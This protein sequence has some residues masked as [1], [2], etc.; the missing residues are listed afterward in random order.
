MQAKLKELGIY[1]PDNTTIVEMT[2]PSASKTSNL[3]PISEIIKLTGDPKKGAVVSA[4]CYTCHQIEGNGIA[5]GP[6]LRNWVANQGVEPFLR[7]VIDPSA[8][9]AHGFNGADVLLRD[10]RRIHGLAINQRDPV[11]VQSL[12]GLT[13]V[14]PQK[15]VAKVG[16]LKRSLMLS[17]DQLGLTAQDLADLVAFCATLK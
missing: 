14:I 17:A 4:K 6:D 3:P 10:G 9:I 15:Q 7:A 2:V 8:E 5:Y 11:I 16:K 12:G 13:Q 1:D